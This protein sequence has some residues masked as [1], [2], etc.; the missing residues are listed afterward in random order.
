MDNGNV[1]EEG[2]VPFSGFV[3]DIVV[4]SYCIGEVHTTHVS[5]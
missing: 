1:K 2:P 5:E 3:E 4:P